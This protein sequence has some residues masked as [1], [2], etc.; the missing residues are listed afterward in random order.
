MGLRDVRLIVMCGQE[1]IH[2]YGFCLGF[3]ASLSI[4]RS[5]EHQ[6]RMYLRL[7]MLHRGG[8]MIPTA[9]LR[10]R[11]SGSEREWLP[12]AMPTMVVRA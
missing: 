2:D 8:P 5:N 9:L 6:I 7:R 1:H 11:A 12:K 10:F 3:L 4:Q